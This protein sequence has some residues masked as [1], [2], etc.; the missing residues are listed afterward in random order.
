[1]Y[2]VAHRHDS[3]T[4]SLDLLT[5]S[6]RYVGQ[7]PGGGGLD[8]DEFAREALTVELRARL[9]CLPVFLSEKVREQY[10]KVISPGPSLPPVRPQSLA[11]S[12]S[13]TAVV[14]TSCAPRAGH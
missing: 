1:M 8:Y 9:G 13:T 10:Y 5:H 4:R 12:H 7:L 11:R 14:R 3:R 2:V 6:V